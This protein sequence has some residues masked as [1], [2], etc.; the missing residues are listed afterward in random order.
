MKID[1]D[2]SMESVYGRLAGRFQ[3]AVAESLCADPVSQN[4]RVEIPS[5][6]PECDESE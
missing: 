1:L 2:A 5:A 6:A 3:A 4:T